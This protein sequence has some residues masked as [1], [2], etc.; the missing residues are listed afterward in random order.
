MSK[1]L[2]TKEDAKNAVYGGCILGGGG[3]GW[4]RDGLEKAEQAFSAGS[5]TLISVDELNDEDHV[6]CVSLVGAPSAKQQYVD[7]QQLIDTVNRMQREYKHSIKALMT[8]ENGAAT[9]INGWLQSAA[10]G[11]PFLDAPCNG[12]AHPTGSMG[13]LNLSEVNDYLS[14]QTFSG[15]AGE[16]KI[17]GTIAASLDLSSNVVRTASVQAGGMVGVCRNPIHIRY[18][19]ENAAIGGITQAIKLEEVFFSAPEGPERIETVSSFLKGRIIHAGKVSRF[20]MDA[21]GGFDVG[22]VQIDDL[23]LTFWNEYMTAEMN[24]ERKGTF[25][26][27]IMTFDAESGLPVVSAEIEEG[28]NIAVISVPKENLKLSSTMFNEKLLKA[29]EP[30]MHKKIV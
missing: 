16:K 26:D 20:E 8:N 13:S 30:I 22:V 10:T 14:I 23:E 4:I 7:S 9:T 27:L 12:R 18:V 3:G 24:G 6:A 29:I 17:E 15:G 28:L 25:P 11:L 21:T 19:K 1:K 5:P 2:L